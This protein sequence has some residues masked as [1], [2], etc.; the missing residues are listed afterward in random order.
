LKLSNFTQSKDNNFNL[1]RIVAALAVLITHSFAL[2]N[3]TGD[4]EPFRFSLGMTMGSIAVDV[5]FITS[6]FLVTASLLTRQSAIEFVWARLLRIF[7]ALLVMLFLTVFGLGIFF[8]SLPLSS[9]LAESK[10]YIYLSKCST[11]ITGVAYNL[12][13]VF[14]GNPF[15]N[16]VNGSLWSMRY[17]IRM[18]VILAFLWIA[19]RTVKG[20]RIR[21]FEIAVVASTIVAGVAVANYLLTL[22]S[23]YLVTQGVFLK[24]FFMF[25]SGSAFYVL[26]E[27]IRLSHSFFGLFVIALLL[28]AIVNKHAYFLIYTLTIA[29]VLFYLAYVPAGHI[30]K[31]NYVGDYSYGVYIYA[32]P[33]QQSVAAL[34]PG[35]SVLSMV[36]ISASVT[37]LLAAISWHFLERRMLSL[38]GIYVGHTRRLLT[39]RLTVMADRRPS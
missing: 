2:V 38:K 33:V 28:S 7:P 8:T 10:T 31:Y 6:G 13:G 15:K 34:V 26:K 5:F 37:I 14:D 36:L 1:I 20:I 23:E 17:E 21:V 27:H 19:L 24:F 3:G 25:F 29:Y 4:A 11:L 9:Y 32:F 39:D 22:P 30:R 16:V 12:P 35:V 18:Y